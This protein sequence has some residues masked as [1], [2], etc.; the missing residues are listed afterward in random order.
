MNCEWQVVHKVAAEQP[1]RLALEPVGPFQPGRLHPPRRSADT[2][3]YEV[4]ACPRTDEP[5]VRKQLT[6]QGHQLLL[7]WE[8]EGAEDNVWDLLVQCAVDDLILLRVTLETDGRRASA[9]NLEAFNLALEPLPTTLRNVRRRPQKEYALPVTGGCLT[10]RP[11]E[12]GAGNP[13]WQRLVAEATRPDHR[14]AV[15]DA[16]IRLAGELHELRVVCHLSK[17]VDIGVDHPAAAPFVEAS[18]D[19]SDDLVLAQPVEWESPDIGRAHTERVLR[20][21]RRIMSTR[22]WTRSAW[23]IVGMPLC[24][25]ARVANP[26]ARRTRTYGRHWLLRSGTTAPRY[27]RLRDAAS[28]TSSTRRPAEPSVTGDRPSRIA[29]ANSAITPASA[30]RSGRAGATMSPDR[31]EISASR[32]WSAPM[33]FGSLRSTPR[34]KTLR[35][36]D[37]LRSSHS[38][39]RLDPPI[40]IV[41]T[42]VGL[43]QLTCACAIAPPAS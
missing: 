20:R 13:L 27:S 16:E 11:D 32:R 42:F 30:S 23:P 3:R 41:R 25:L 26:T 29:S 33:L 38:S 6:K 15:S 28:R 36:C 34:S 22:F 1:A 21:L 24:L 18:H 9:N 35:R 7:L 2:A 14:H 39:V 19:E 43:S 17:N 4:E 37:G 12:G 8:S 40:I 31:Y 10:Q 5:A